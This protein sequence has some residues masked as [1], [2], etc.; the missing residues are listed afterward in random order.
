MQKWINGQRHQTNKQKSSL[1]KEKV[2]DVLCPSLFDMVMLSNT[3]K[4]KDKYLVGTSCA[5][6]MS[7]F[8]TSGALIIWL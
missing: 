4:S 3:D 1:I 7:L 5:Q 6:N 8:G 2:L